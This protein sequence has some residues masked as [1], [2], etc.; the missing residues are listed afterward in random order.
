MSR[1]PAVVLQPVVM[2]PMMMHAPMMPVQRGGGGGYVRPLLL[3]YQYI[4]THTKSAS[5]LLAAVGR[6]GPAQP[7]HPQQMMQLPPEIQEI[8]QLS[9]EQVSPSATSPLAY[10]PVRCF[11]WTLHHRQPFLPM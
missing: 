10:R 4:H 1:G 3:H 9:D 11:T 8:M 5:H 6:Y 2:A 7:Q